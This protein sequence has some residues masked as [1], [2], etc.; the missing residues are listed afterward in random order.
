MKQF[1]ALIAA[2]LMAGV[3]YAEPVKE[4]AKKDHPRFEKQDGHQFQH[5]HHGEKH[6]HHQGMREQERRPEMQ[7]RRGFGPGPMMRG[8]MQ[9]HGPGPMMRGPRGPMQGHGPGP[10]M[11]GPMQ[12]RGFGPG[13]MMRG[14]RGP[15]Q[16]HG[17]GPMMHGPGPR[18]DQDQPLMPPVHRKWDKEKPTV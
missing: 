11:R 2:L 13:P 7:G 17:P 18:E 15:M 12:G 9:G 16:G 8:P 14:P 4:P 10:M 5:R 3:A 6:K 1:V